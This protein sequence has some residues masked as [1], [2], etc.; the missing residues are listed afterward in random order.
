MTRSRLTLL[1]TF[2]LTLSVA[3]SLPGIGTPKRQ[4]SLATP[5]PPPPPTAPPRSD[6][7]PALIETDPPLGSEIAPQEGIT[8]YFNQPMQRASVE[9]A[10]RS[11]SGIAGRFEWLDEAT[12]TFFPQTPFTPESDLLLTLDTGAQAQNG[13]EL[14]RPVAVHFRVAGPLRATQFLP[15]PDAEGVSPTSAVV[16]TFNR[17]VVPLGADSA[18]LPPAFTLDPPAQGHG[19]WLNSS[20]YIFSPEPAL[21]GGNTYQVRL[22]PALHSTAGTPLQEAVTWTFST[23][24]PAVTEITP[25]PTYPLPPDG[26]FTLRFNQPMN[27]PSVEAALSFSGPEGKVPFQSEWDE[28]FTTL[29]LRPTGLLARNADY[30]L[31]LGAMAQ[32]AGQAFLGEV[33]KVSWHTY[34]ALQALGLSTTTVRPGEA[35]ELRFSAPLPSPDKTD[36]TPFLRVEPQADIRNLYWNSWEGKTTLRVYGD[37]QSDTDYTLFLSA[38][39]PDAWGGRL[40]APVQFSFHVSGLEP[41]LEFGVAAF[42]SSVFIAALSDGGLPVHAANIESAALWSAPLSLEDFIRLTT[43]DDYNALDDFSPPQLQYREN[44]ID[45]PSDRM[46]Q[47]TLPLPG[48]APGVYYVKA[49]PPTTGASLTQARPALVV[50]TNV[51]LT[52]KYGQRDA[53]VWATYLDSGQPVAGAPVR[54]YG[55]GGR[56]LAQGQ[57][58][59]QGLFHAEGMNT[60]DNPDDALA[61]LGKPGDAYFS[62]ALTSMNAGL[63]PWNSKVSVSYTP[64]PLTIYLYTDR[65]IYRPG[66]SVHFRAVV[67]QAF[68]GRYDLP[69]TDT[70]SVLLRGS[71][72]EELKRFSLPLTE[73]GTASGEFTLPEDAPPGYYTLEVVDTYARLSFQVAEYRKPEFELEVRTSAEDLLAGETLAAEAEARYYFGAPAG[74]ME[75]HWAVYLAPDWFA[76]PGYAVGPDDVDWFASFPSWMFGPPMEEIASGNAKTDAAGRFR[77]EVPLPQKAFIQRYVVEVTAMDESGFPVSARAEGRLHPAE[78]YIGVRAEQWAAPAGSERT[79]EVRTVSWEREPSGGRPLSVQFSRVTWERHPAPYESETATY[80]KVVSPIAETHITTDGQGTGRVAFTP[81]KSGMYQITLQ[82]G[83][84][85]TEYLFW[86]GGSGSGTWPELPNQAL[87]LSADKETYR[88]GEKA[89]VF[90]ANPFGVETQALVTL[91]RGTLHRYEVHL[92]PAGGGTLE[93][94]LGEAEA[95]NIYLSVTLPGQRPDGRPDFRYGILNLPVEPERLTLRVEMLD[96]PAQTGPRSEVTLRL[97][98]SDADGNPVQGAFSLAVVD[99]AVLALADPNSFSIEDAFYGTQPLSI[100][101]GMGLA[102]YALRAV[103]QPGGMGGGGGEVTTPLRQEFPDTAYWKGEIVTDGNGEALVRLTLPDSLTTWVLDARGVTRN[104]L[105]GQ[106]QSEITVT[107]PL[108][109]RPVTPRFVT[110]GD[111]FP[112][113]AIVHNNTE[114]PLQVNVQLQAP[115]FALD[116]PAQAV[117]A[118]SVEPGGRAYVE[119]WGTVQEAAALETV[120]SAEGGRWKDAAK[121]VWGDLPV[122][123]Y[124][125]QQTYG[126]SGVLS[127][128]GEVL[129]A[130]SLPRTFVPAGGDLQVEMAPSL[131]ADMLSA[132]DVLEHYPYECIEQTLS[133]F[134]PNLAAYQAVRD[135]GLQSPELEARLERTVGQGVTRLVEAQNED[136]GWGWWQGGESNTYIS[137][138]VLFGLTQARQSGAEVPDN[139]LQQAARYLEASLTLPT[140]GMHDWVLD[141]TAMTLFALQ[142]YGQEAPLV[143]E[144]LYGL[145]ARLSPAAQALLALTFPQGSEPSDILL[146]DLQGSALRSATGAHWEAARSLRINLAS[147]V[148]STAAVVYALAQRQPASSLLPEAVRYLVAARRG[149][150]WATTYETAWSLLALTEVMRGTGELAGDFDF[151]ATLNSA[152]LLTGN[153]AGDAQFNPVRAVTPLSHLYPDA[154]NALI[155]RRGEGSGRL[156]YRIYLNALMPVAGLPPLS[157]GFS[158]ERRYYPPG[159]PQA[160]KALT[161]APAGQMVEV[162]LTLVVPEEA[163]YVAVEDYLPAGAEVL[164]TSLKTSQQEGIPSLEPT[165]PFADGWMWWLFS[166][167]KVYDD[168]IAWTAEYLPPGTYDLKYTLVLTQ[169]GEYRVLPARAFEFYFPEVQGRGEG[170]V[171]IIEARP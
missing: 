148:Q 17:P 9:A 67:R 82:G 27:P 153:A 131:A 81:D 166:P 52:L 84:G 143:R 31:Q 169:P 18:A 42:G 78:F 43:S 115:A 133:R 109:V 116:D 126:T 124:V 161:S 113:A 154:P 47:R 134:L 6:L 32:S 127:Q 110:L 102:A 111:H 128:P 159:E 36:L 139:V 151:S 24:P 22:N 74:G 35:L 64:P 28:T 38:D 1:L 129:E 93:I 140:P 112:L 121:P 158:V 171:F 63:I 160:E 92:I 58:D 71:E 65:P 45:A 56:L 54:L 11:E 164:D 83:G 142:A 149:A 107:K 165:R 86:V 76:L 105:V 167:P 10:L 108:L 90:V 3:C 125:A 118:V 75:L 41:R 104:S 170:E 114:E 44:R 61:I 145:R 87:P 72:Y 163:H 85:F 21:F 30:L 135:F 100:R 91:E 96:L 117:Q 132:L 103:E 62:A 12:V 7:P 29:T 122:V 79:F 156:Y 34:P 95:P 94:P 147:D 2:L 155:L 33:L 152:P 5:T 80:E 69:K 25:D 46:V 144:Q 60:A 137:A 55:G 168:H 23:A 51:N 77:V 106:A 150:S 14:A 120:F 68:D 15:E 130:I 101:T 73:F 146:S 123:R 8:F 141:R 119:W 59:S 66:Q 98:V 162:H 37:F 136:G 13:K 53:L 88:P 20:T 50:L 49:A 99:K 57:T 26:V 48:N 70:I 40:G 19:E 97:H 39:L 89:Q 157:Q 4:Q 16:V 138:Y